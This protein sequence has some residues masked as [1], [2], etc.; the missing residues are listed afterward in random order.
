[1]AEI[2]LLNDYLLTAPFSNDNAGFSR[3]TFG[4]R[5]GETY[6]IK[7]YLTPV[8]PMEPTLT[9]ETREKRIEAC[10]KFEEEHTRLCQA[11]NSVT[12]GNLIPI[13]EFFRYGP[14]YYIT[15]RKV[16]SVNISPED[17]A[18]LPYRTRCYTVLAL[19]HS[20]LCLHEKGLIHADLKPEN[21]L[22]EKLPGGGMAPRLVDIGSAFFEKEPPESSAS[23][24][25]DQ[26]YMS[27]EAVMFICGEEVFLTCAMDV[28]SMGLLIHYYMTGHLPGYGKEYFYPNEAVL[29]GQKLI[30][31]NS[32]PEDFRKLIECMLEADPLKRPAMQEVCSRIRDIMGLKEPEETEEALAEAGAA[33][34]KETGNKED[35]GNASFGSSASGNWFR[36]AGN[37]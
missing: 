6:F 19:C 24:E 9:S 3:W 16:D 13:N 17:F 26:V 28:F 4:T 23:L 30:F 29:D 35:P 25:G 31:E 34:E 21:I 14:R 33:A 27:P 8:Y 12:D 2:G 10:R 11:V 37:L 1:M 7:E 15:T 36:K 20:V 18:H 5:D 22:M 32:L